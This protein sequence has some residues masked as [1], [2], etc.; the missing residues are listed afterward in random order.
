MV[1]FINYYKFVNKFRFIVWIV[2]KTLNNNYNRL[3]I[4][5]IIKRNLF[6]AKKNLNNNGNCY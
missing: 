4:V 6:L 2:L 5:T 3:L 1:Y